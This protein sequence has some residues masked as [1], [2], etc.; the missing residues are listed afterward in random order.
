[1][2]LLRPVRRSIEQAQGAEGSPDLGDTHSTIRLE[3]HSLRCID[4]DLIVIEKDDVV[5]GTAEVSE[6]MLKGGA[7]RLEVT[8]LV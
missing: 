5:R 8:D 4:V 3:S 1:V 2:Y 6:D 7:R